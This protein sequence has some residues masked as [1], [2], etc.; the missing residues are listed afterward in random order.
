M[1]AR[2]DETYKAIRAATYGIAFFATPHQGCNGARLGEIA[3]TIANI[4]LRNPK[5]TFLDALKKD[6]LFADGLTA[7]F[8]YQLEDFHILSFF[9]TRPYRKLGLVSQP[10]WSMPV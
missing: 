3:A 9:E 5:N 4:L 2:L 10:H 1:T 8:R 7:D 6:S